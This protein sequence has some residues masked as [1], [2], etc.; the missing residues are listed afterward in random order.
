MV[1]ATATKV[2][3]AEMKLVSGGSDYFNS[4]MVAE[5]HGAEL[6]L[7]NTV[8]SRLS[9][10]PVSFKQT[11]ERWFWLGNSPGRGLWLPER[12]RMDF[13]RMRIAPILSEKEWSTLPTSEIAITFKGMGHLLAKVT[14]DGALIINAATNR[15][16]VSSC[17]LMSARSRQPASTS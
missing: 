14:H 15:S 1:V 3:T 17:I 12:G 10:D 2:A 9:S 7:L 6:I 16:S 4:S 11:D 5:K 8:I 13:E